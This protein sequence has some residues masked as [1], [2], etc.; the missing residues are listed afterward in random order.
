MKVEVAALLKKAASSRRAADLLA[1]QLYIDFA[2]SRAYYALF[3]LAEALLLAEGLA[4]SSHSAVIAGFGKTFA[5]TGRLDPRF[6]RFL[7]DA[8]DLRAL[9]DYGVGTGVSQEQLKDLLSWYD[10]FYQAAISAL[11]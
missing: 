1:S 11:E 5:R 9:G 10:E 4:F 3:Y 7:I 6:H 2:A 8:Q